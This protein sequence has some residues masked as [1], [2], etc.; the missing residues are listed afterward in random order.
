[1]GEIETYGKR[2]KTHGVFGTHCDILGDKL[3][4]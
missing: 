4:A 2:G 1:M 3:T